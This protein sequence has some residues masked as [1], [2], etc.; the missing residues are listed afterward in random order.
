MQPPMENIAV[1]TKTADKPLLL[2]HEKKGL[3][4][5]AVLKGE[6]R[7]GEEEGSV[8]QREHS[9]VCRWLQSGPHTLA[10]LTPLCTQFLLH[11]C[12]YTHINARIYTHKYSHTHK[13]LHTH[14]HTLTHTH[15]YTHTHLHTNKH[16]LTHAHTHT[17]T[18]SLADTHTGAAKP[19]GRGN[20]SQPHCV[21]PQDLHDLLRP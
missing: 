17:H 14:T 12:T 18:H 20:E 9:E 4:V 10:G 15:T 3:D 2:A 16:T 1:G 19:D 8:W 6:G 11:V 13:H 7:R 21:A 5:S